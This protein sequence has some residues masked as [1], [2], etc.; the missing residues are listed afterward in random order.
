VPSG[1]PVPVP[2]VPLQVA[3]KPAGADASYQMVIVHG[4]SGAS[5]QL[6]S[7]TQP[8][9]AKPPPPVAPS[10]ATSKSAYAGADIS[11]GCEITPSFGRLGNGTPVNSGMASVCSKVISSIFVQFPKAVVLSSTCPLNVKDVSASL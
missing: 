2:A 5:P 11:Q 7:N 4:S 8:F 1:S 6:S 9:A 10:N 3:L